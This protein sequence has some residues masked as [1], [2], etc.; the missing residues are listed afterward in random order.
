MTFGDNPLRHLMNNERGTQAA[1]GTAAQAETLNPA[2]FAKAERLL[3]EHETTLDSFTDLYGPESIARD[4]QYVAS[5]ETFFAKKEQE[6]RR[7]GHV[8]AEAVNQ[9]SKVFEAMA[10]EG[11]R[12]HGWLGPDVVPFR[13]TRFDDYKNGIDLVTEIQRGEDPAEHLALAIDVT[14]GQKAQ[15]RKFERIREEILKED[16][17]KIKYFRSERNGFRGELSMIPKVI[18]GIE[19][20]NVMRMSRLW[21]NDEKKL[22]ILPAQMAMLEEVRDQLEAFSTFAK[23]NNKIPVIRVYAQAKRIVARIIGEKKKLMNYQ[24]LDDDRVYRAILESARM[25]NS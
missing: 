3:S 13:T 5:C 19:P 9:A 14:F 10:F 23:Q 2:V 21:A 24:T 22:A 20:R 1:R 12:A 7:E 15:E 8:H 17:G 11:I 25:F 16:L 4:Q 6:Q 18:V